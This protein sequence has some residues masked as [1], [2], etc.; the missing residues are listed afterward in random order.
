MPPWIS[1]ITADTDLLGKTIAE[2][3]SPVNRRVSINVR[4]GGFTVE[5]KQLHT[6]FG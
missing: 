2:Y 5:G 6:R 3:G 1:S 4:A